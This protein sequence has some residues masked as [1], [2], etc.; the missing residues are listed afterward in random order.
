MLIH[1]VWS[2]VMMIFMNLVPR[3]QNCSE[4]WLLIMLIPQNKQYSNMPW[5]SGLPLSKLSYDCNCRGA[6]LRLRPRR[7]RRV[8]RR[9]RGPLLPR[10]T[11]SRD[12]VSAAAAPPYSEHGA[13]LRGCTR[14][15]SS[16]DS[17]SGFMHHAS[18]MF[19][20]VTST[21]EMYFDEL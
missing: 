14:H 4:S 20:G 17:T 6:H 1:V 21:F 9:A 12:W 10:Q 16:P 15:D 7:R 19:A 11:S 2:I 8:R 13:A 3:I 5:L 18:C